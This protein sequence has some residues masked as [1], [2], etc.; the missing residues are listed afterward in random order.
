MPPLVHSSF[1][2]LQ[3]KLDQATRSK[4]QMIKRMAKA[5]ED[6]DDLKF[7]LEEKNIEFEGTRAQLRVLESRSGHHPVARNSTS[8]LSSHEDLLVDMDSSSSARVAVSTASMRAMV[9]LLMTD[10]VQLQHSSSTE[11][12][13]DHT[14]QQ[15]RHPH[16]QQHDSTTTTPKKRIPSRIPLPGSAATTVTATPTGLKAPTKPP[17]GRKASVGYSGPPSNR[18]LNQLRQMS[19]SSSSLNNNNN[20]NRKETSLTRPESANS[21]RNSYQT[22]LPLATTPPSREMSHA[23][24]NTPS[25]YR[26]SNSS[27][28]SIPISTTASVTSVGSSA[29]KLSTSPEKKNHSLG[30]NNKSL[31]SASSGNL[32][33][34]NLMDSLTAG[35]ATTTTPTSQ[36]QLLAV[37]SPGNSM[38][39]KLSS[40]NS[41]TTPITMILN[42]NNN[43]KSHSQSNLSQHG[44]MGGKASAV[45]VRRASASRTS[46]GSN[47]AGTPTTTT[48]NGDEGNGGDNGKVRNLRS[49][50]WN[51]LKI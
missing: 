22:Q 51:W 35:A 10:D 31:K 36:S 25:P 15:Q 46:I 38:S 18:S 21:W 49:S 19:A 28:S 23:T 42:N 30:G 9:P 50:I 32:R 17:S 45:P 3:Q 26:N 11:S 5:Q 40:T 34:R 48:N 4:I 20:N 47:N 41:S 44:R 14:E 37:K 8:L 2:V 6:M 24:Q 29:S 7:Q 33:A 1:Q 13:H 12:A 43:N 16:P 39:S 27:V